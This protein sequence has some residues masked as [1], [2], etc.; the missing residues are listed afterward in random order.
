M[1]SKKQQRGLIILLIVVLLIQ[2]FPILTFAETS[3]QKYYYDTFIKTKKDKG[4]S[5]EESVEKGDKHFGW[6]LGKFVVEGYTNIKDEK[7]NK[8]F[9]KNVDDTV[10]LSF[11]LDQ[12]IDKLNGDEKLTIARDK[13]GYDKY[14][15]ENSQDFGRGALIV[16]YTDYRN[17]SKQ[18]VN[19]DY[20][21]GL[22][23]G[24]NTQIKLYEEGDYEIALNYKVKKTH[25]NI[26]KVN[27]LPTETDYRI[28]FKFSVRNGNCMVYPFDV[29]TGDELSSSS[30][31]V[32]GFRLD[33]AKS[34]YHDVNIKKEILTKTADG[35]IE[36]TRFNKSAK[37]GDEYTD[38][39]IYTITVTNRY[40]SVKTI[41]KI[42]V[43]ENSLLKGHFA[44]GLPV[45][46]IKDM[47]KRGATI[48]DD[49][50]IVT[51]ADA[52]T[53]DSKSSGHLD[54][55]ESA[56]IDNE[57]KD[58]NTTISKTNKFKIVW[59]AIIAIVVIFV[60]LGLWK[61]HESSEKLYTNIQNRDDEDRKGDDEGEYE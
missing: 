42:Y 30:M 51:P 4:Y 61:K 44:T 34:D 52:P 13:D 48:N 12:D 32:N 10:T 16:K 49:G 40:T 59:V 3:G 58:E 36:D 24:A 9:L 5:L 22:T 28:F 33:L 45:D 23:V 31:T 50:G 11:C 39:G 20:L 1:K 7:D 38:E 18:N 8:V 14:F 46:E 25:I 60:T 54:A 19:T 35:I 37:D 55:E 21:S 57:S 15:Q 41:K 47:I 56:E 29:G 26:R 53:T 43:G 6:T 2:M 27:T 17:A